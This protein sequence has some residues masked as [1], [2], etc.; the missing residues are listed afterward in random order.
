LAASVR[1]TEEVNI[2]ITDPSIYSIQ[3]A[4]LRTEE[5]HRMKLAEEKKQGVRSRI[6]ALRDTFRKLTTKNIESEEWIRLT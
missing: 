5:D 1:L 2:D 3:Q 4:K 6:Q